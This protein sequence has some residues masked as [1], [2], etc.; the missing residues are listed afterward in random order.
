MVE[1]ITSLMN[2]AL[3][4]MV[5]RLLIFLLIFSSVALSETTNLDTILIKR[6]GYALEQSYNEKFYLAEDSL[7]E[8]LK[9]YPAEK[10]LINSLFISVKYSKMKDSED[11][12]EK[13]KVLASID[14]LILQLE[15][16]P[17][18]MSINDY[19]LGLLYLYKGLIL[20]DTEGSVFSVIK[21]IQKST[22]HFENSS[23]DENLRYDSY[24]GLGSYKFFKSSKAGFIRKIKLVKDEREIGIEMLKKCS[25]YS[26]FSRLPAIHSL[27]NSY[28]ELEDFGKAESLLNYMLK[29]NPSSRTALWNAINVYYKQKD[30]KNALKYANLLETKLPAGNG[31]NLIEVA[32]Y[33]TDC[34]LKLGN[35]EKA[36]EKSKKILNLSVPI[37]IRDRQD[38][39]LEY[40]RDVIKDYR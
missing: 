35:I 29:I 3:I 30:Y 13:S 9:S 8:I 1:R 23:L 6:L 4:L 20:N 21:Y 22:N 38:K 12:G 15:S 37:E 27:I 2:M 10:K 5:N 31:F 24:L 25:E 36:I 28:I 19:C 11:F 39:R 40:F 34:N 14:S 16:T 7:K 26:H 32:Y 17:S 33:Q 18:D